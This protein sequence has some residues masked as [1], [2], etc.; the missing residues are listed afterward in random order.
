MPRK[1]KQSP[2]NSARRVAVSLLLA[3]CSLSLSYTL[4]CFS[5]D[6]RLPSPPLVSPLRWSVRFGS[7]TQP[8]VGG[9]F[10][11]MLALPS[12][13]WPKDWRVREFLLSATRTTDCL[14]QS[15]VDGSG[16]VGPTELHTSWILGGL[17]L[18][19]HGCRAKNE[20]LGF[21]FVRAPTCCARCSFGGFFIPSPISPP[22]ISS[23][24]AR[25]S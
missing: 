21:L 16:L 23:S 11:H 25:S 20:C 10:S 15:V 12:M 6:F 4:C 9:W 3:C 8:Y 24:F 13:E 19:F 22:F 7:D 2:P 17:V 18:R 5:G 1:E 14:G